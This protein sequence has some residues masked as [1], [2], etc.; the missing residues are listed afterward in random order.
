MQQRPEK[1]WTLNPIM[2]ERTQQV[3]ALAAKA[4]EPSLIGR[5]RKP[6]LDFQLSAV[7]HNTPPMQ[8]NCIKVWI[9]H[10]TS[11]YLH[12]FSSRLRSQ[13]PQTNSIYT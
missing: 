8:F 9:L 10:A 12:L 2:E 6:P 3:K 7:A 5:E 13:D 1:S 4:E 11:T